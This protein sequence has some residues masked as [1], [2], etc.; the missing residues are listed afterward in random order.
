MSL[1]WIGKLIDMK[2]HLLSITLVLGCFT[3]SIGV[4]ATADA[5]PGYTG[6]TAKLA[7]RNHLP[8]L[9]AEQKLDFTVGK[10]FFKRIWVSAPAS[11]QAADGLGP[12]YNARS[13]IACHPNNGRG[14]PPE[15]NTEKAKSMVLKIDIPAQ[16]KAQ[17][18]LL[19]K[20]E[21]NNIP[22]PVYGLQLQ[23]FAVA[24]HES[25]SEL[26]VSYREVPVTLSDGEVVM[27]R[28]PVYQVN[29][30]SYGKLHPDTRFSPRVAPQLI[31]LGLLDAID[32]Q[33]LIALVDEEDRD[34]NGISG[35]LNRVWSR[36]YAKVMPGRFGYKSGSPSVNEQSQ[37]AFFTDIGISTP[38]YPEGYGDCMTAQRDCIAAPDGNSPQ[39]DNLEAPRQVTELVDFYVSNIAPPPQRNR[40]HEDVKAGRALFE[41]IGCSGCHVPTFDVT[42]NNRRQQIH[43]YTD[44]LLHDMGEGLADHRP[45]GLASG[46]EWRTAP[47]WGIG[48][49]PA[50]SGHSYYLH[51]GRARSL[52][53]AI[54]WHGGEA[55]KQR[56][57]VVALDKRQRA[58]LLKFIESI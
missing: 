22:E 43:P 3:G 18:G 42:H 36:E 31:G 1:C 27:L 5:T 51:D 17:Q 7:F 58:Q 33:E 16:T 15:N 47:L 53:E 10:G 41:Q 50:V 9:S 40:E 45:E 4:S 30:L 49:S 52:M 26:K 19:A 29:N 54:L 34:G 46:S 6:N 21:T 12:L 56:D 2:K 48:L 28:K 44:L 32:E 14:K 37:S 24:G 39:F 38:L 8:G 13:C 35:K 25:E 57:A 20:Y 55:Q 11:T 23:N